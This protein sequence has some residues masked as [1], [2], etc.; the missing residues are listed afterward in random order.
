MLADQPIFASLPAADLARA[1]TWYAER[2]DLKP[3]EEDSAGNFWFE[4]GGARFFVYESQFA[5]TNQATA[6][7]WTVDDVTGTV[8]ELRGRGVVFE[9]YDMGEYVTQDGVMTLPDGSKGAWMKDSEG[10]ILGLFQ[11]A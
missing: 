3:I 11:Q 4:T 8:A 5:G 1:R 10:N 6:A 2:L 7:A 9:E